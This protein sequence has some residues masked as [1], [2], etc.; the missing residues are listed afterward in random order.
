[1]FSGRTAIS[2]RCSPTAARSVVVTI[3]TAVVVMLCPAV[4]PVNPVA[5][6]GGQSRPPQ[7][8]PE[9][10]H[11]ASRGCVVI[12]TNGSSR[13]R[14]AHCGARSRTIDGEAARLRRGERDGAVASQR[15]SQAALARARPPPVVAVL[16]GE[17]SQPHAARLQDDRPARAQWSLPDDLLHGVPQQGY[18]DREAVL[19]P[20]PGPREV[21]HERLP[22]GAGDPTR[23]GGRRRRPWRHRGRG[24][25]RR[26][27][28]PRG[29]AAPGSP[30]GSGPSAS[31]RCR[32]W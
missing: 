9:H 17:R 30:R 11:L 19:H 4:R 31:G 28:A 2:M 14:P 6:V 15:T 13:V 29:R 24:P 18:D 23:Q 20:A 32:R 3:A 16:R 25:P 10:R 21:H 27:P 12:I 7:V 5:E 8:M 22:D 26:S 1:M